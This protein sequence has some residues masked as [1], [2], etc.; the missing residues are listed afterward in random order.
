MF[1][2]SK[3]AE[4]FSC[5]R[6]KT[7]AIVKFALAPALN[8]D[9]TKAC[10]TSPF[11]LL[12]DGGNDQSGKKYFAI[13]VRI[14]DNTKRQAMTRFLA[15]PVC[16]DAT[17]AALF[18]AVSSEL[19]SRDIPWKNVIGYAS[20]TA[21]VMV[22]VRNSV[23]SRIKQKQPNVFS[24][25]CMCHL[26]ALCAVAALKKLPV[27]VDDFLIDISYH[28]KYSA[29]RWSQYTEIREEFS[30]MKPLKILKHCTTRRLS[31]ERCIR[32]IIDQWPALHA[33]FDREVDI[34]PS[35]E[36]VQRIAQQLRKPLVKLICHFVSFALKPLN[37]FNI[38]FQTHASRIGSL[39]SDVR[40]LL[41]G[42]LSNF[43]KP[44][45]SL[46]YR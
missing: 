30:E 20:D 33:Y 18:T 14:W 7:T 29:K 28:F 25:G 37:K 15:M 22:G 24:L 11:T 1:P 40:S 34:E 32:R 13:M 17:A 5:G 8:A 19:E 38:A 41:Q 2:Y 46:R 26:A 43:I 45:S 4:G 44:G 23:L 16:N 10:Q 36:R 9:V 39:Q 27:S 3:V 21:S 6:T 31:L 42:Y 12:C 35:N